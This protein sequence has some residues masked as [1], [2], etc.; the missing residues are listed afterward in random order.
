VKRIWLC[1]L[2]PKASYKKLTSRLYKNNENMETISDNEESAIFDRS[3]DTSAYEI[4]RNVLK[5]LKV[6]TM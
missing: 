4:K 5:A 1:I 3:F 6:A 2:Y